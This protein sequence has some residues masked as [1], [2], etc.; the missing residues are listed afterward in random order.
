MPYIS[1]WVIGRG[2]NCDNWTVC[3]VLPLL[4][5][6]RYGWGKSSDPRKTVVDRKV[7]ESTMTIWTQFARTGNPNVEDLMTCPVYESASGR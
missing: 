2:S 7:S 3:S 1:G 4:G 6:T 5:I